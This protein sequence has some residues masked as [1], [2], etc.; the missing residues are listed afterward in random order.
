VLAV[1]IVVG[2][3][4]GAASLWWLLRTGAEPPPP[5]SPESMLMPPNL[6]KTDPAALTL[7]EKLQRFY[8]GDPEP[9]A[10]S[11]DDLNHLLKLVQ[12]ELAQQ[13]KLGIDDGYVVLDGVFP[14][15]E[16]GLGQMQLQGKIWLRLDHSEHRTAVFIEAMQLAGLALPAIV[17]QR[18]RQVDLAQR[19]RQ[20]DD[21]LLREALADFEARI[22]ALAVY[23]NRIVVWPRPR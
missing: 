15:A 6:A 20:H 11:A 5:R 1:V 17:Q 12:P 22:E 3:A 23:P 8:A 13:L 14:M 7:E 18:L 4:A 9:L 19:L 10:Y 2:I 21:P 16:L